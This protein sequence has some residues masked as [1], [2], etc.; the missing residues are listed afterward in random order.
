MGTT[1]HGSAAGGGGIIGGSYGQVFTGSG[2]PVST[3]SHLAI[4]Y[5]GSTV[6]LYLNGA[7]VDSVAHTGLITSSTNA[8][9]LGSDPF[10]GQYFNG[11]IDEVRIYNKALTA[12]Q[13]Q[14]DMNTAVGVVPSTPDEPY[15]DGGKHERRSTS[16]GALRPTARASRDTGS[17]AAKALAARTSPRSRR[18]QEPRTPTQV[19]RPGRPTSI[20]SGPSIRAE[21][22]DRTRILR[23]RLPES[24]SSPRRVALTPG[25][26][27]AVHRLHS[28]APA[29]RR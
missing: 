12:A 5:D 26:D 18:R 14:S 3:W 2:L 27:P 23:P 10:Y 15:G 9:T 8:L 24:C 11:L 7:M 4:T 6:R 22:L 17:S 19:L 16:P 28:R 20:A 29:R 1:D 25:R 13:I 21:P